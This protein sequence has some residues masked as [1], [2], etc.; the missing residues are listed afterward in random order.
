MEDR[1]YTVFK[2]SAA[3]KA[4][5]SEVLKYTYEILS[6]IP[7]EEFEEEYEMFD[8]ESDRKADDTI[9]VSVED[10]V[11]HVEGRRAQFI[12]GSTNMEDYESLQY[13]QRALIKSGVID[14][15]KE[16]GIQ[17]GDPVEIYGCEFDYVE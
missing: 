8:L 5:I 14:K 16:A 17:D 10:G 9:T 3:T 6:K 4:G 11:Y 15:L 7:D 2:I 13:F 1:G 12:V